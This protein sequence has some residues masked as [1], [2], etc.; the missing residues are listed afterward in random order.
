MIARAC[1]FVLLACQPLDVATTAAVLMAGGREANPVVAAALA[2]P[3][4]G[5]LAWL[6]LKVAIA[7]RL[8]QMRV[9]G[10]I[11][12]AALVVAA[13]LYLG[14]VGWNA[15]LLLRYWGST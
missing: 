11:D 14:V 4:A 10:R 9:D 2:N 15:A 8:M 5:L 3:A 7:V 13:G 1:K 6:A 12:V